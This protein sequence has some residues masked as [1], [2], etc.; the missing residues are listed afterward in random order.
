[1]SS[2]KVR[3]GALVIGG[4]LAAFVLAGAPALASTHHAASSV[5]GPEVVAG[6]LHGKPVLAS[7]PIVPVQLAGL[8][9]T[10]HGSLSLGSS[11]SKTHTV[12]TPAGNLV[13]HGTG[14]PTSTQSANPKTCQESDTQDVTF[15]VLAS[16]STGKFAGAS[17]PGAAQIYFTAF[18]PRYTSGSKKGQC[19]FKAQPEAKGAE[20]TFLAS[21]VLTLGS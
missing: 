14:T 13:V 15:S 2:L 20:V 9:D 5:T 3:F 7:N 11:K 4:G 21:V 6:A 12:T 10:G 16:R 17:G 8:I 1:M 19:D 18:A